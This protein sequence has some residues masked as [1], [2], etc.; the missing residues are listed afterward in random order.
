MVHGVDAT[1]QFTY[2]DININVFHVNKGEG[3]PMH[4]HQY[5]HATI[6]HAGSIV[7]RKNNF[8][9][10]LT[11]E[12]GAVNLKENESHELEA[13]EDNTVFVNIFSSTKR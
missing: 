3:I 2:E 5:T 8:E 4:S 12:S 10:I 1:F 6:C 9:K 7:V 11:K 13:L